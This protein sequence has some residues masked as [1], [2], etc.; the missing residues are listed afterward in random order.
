MEPVR[1][2]AHY[3]RLVEL[4][5]SLLNTGAGQEN[6]PLAG[7]LYMVGEAIHAWDQAHY[8]PPSADP[9]GMLAFLMQQHGLTPSDL[10][11]LGD[12]EA[13]SEILASK[14]PLDAREI[15]IPKLPPL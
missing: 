15:S 11:E 1:D 2:E 3:D 10:A 8:P 14:R 4:M 6:H 12:V 13:V 9:S 5:D 7:L